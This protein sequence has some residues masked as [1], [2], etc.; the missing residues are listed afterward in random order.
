MPRSMTGLSVLLAGALMC[1]AGFGAG[2]LG[3]AS[4]SPATVGPQDPTAPPAPDP[5]EI[6]ADVAT[7]QF[8]GGDDGGSGGG[9]GSGGSAPRCTWEVWLGI[10]GGS[11]MPGLNP[12]GP[13]TRDANGVQ[14]TLYQYRCAGD[15]NWNYAWVS[16]EIDVAALAASA[17]ERVARQLPEP[18]LTLTPTD[19]EFGW[20]YVQTPTDF[21]VDGQDWAPV[22][23]TASI[24]PVWLTVT[25]APAS[26]TF[27]PGDPA[28]PG[29]VTCDGEAPLAAYVATAPGACSYTYRN[30]SSTSPYD[31]YHFMTTLTTAW[32]VTW[33]GSTG[34]GELEPLLTSS[35]EPVAVAAIKA[36]VTCTGPRPEQ[37][38]C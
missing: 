4:P 27:E 38:S 9:S 17:R 11:I 25:A 19:T 16:D 3:H 2:Q 6:V 30:E 34:G 35:E 32:T 28:G 15:N 1:V 10:T 33:T 26:L 13:Q 8:Q 5:A 36:L 31:G 37:G 21:R 12:S 14:E 23:V 20:I 7:Q 24:G 29:A 18:T 22:S